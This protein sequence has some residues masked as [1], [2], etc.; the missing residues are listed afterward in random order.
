MKKEKK[1]RR[2]VNMSMKDA[3]TIGAGVGAS[4]DKVG[5]KRELLS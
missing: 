3:T 4:K 1:R 5:A 2:K